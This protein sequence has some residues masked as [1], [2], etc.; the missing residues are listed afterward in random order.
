MG[1]GGV[2][3]HGGDRRL[4]RGA[5][6]WERSARQRGGRRPEPEGVDEEVSAPARRPAG[7]LR[8]L[9]SAFRRWA[10]GSKGGV[11]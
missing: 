4:F 11:G 9:V 6:R 7:R 2:V 1:E 8:G 10:G 3:F 5:Q